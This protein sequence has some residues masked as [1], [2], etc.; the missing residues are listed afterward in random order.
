MSGHTLAVG[1]KWRGETMS[2]RVLVVDDEPD[3]VTLVESR[4]NARGYEVVTAY[5]GAEGLEKCKVLKPDAVMLDIMMPGIDGF[6]MAD[7]MKE[8]PNTSQIP[9]IFLTTTKL[10]FSLCKYGSWSP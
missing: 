8:D 6:T 4:L 7:Q 3:L 10:L 1:K 5:S 9:I 2:K